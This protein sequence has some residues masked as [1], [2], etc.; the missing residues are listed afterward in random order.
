MDYDG[1][2]V[3]S[4]SISTTPNAEAVAIL[5]SLCKDT[6]N[7]VFIVSGKERKTITEWFSSCEWLGMAA[8]HGYFLRYVLFPC[9]YL[10][11]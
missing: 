7:C 5:N 10:L 3:Q 9:T 2:M 11:C 1:T 6:K 8:E 4:G